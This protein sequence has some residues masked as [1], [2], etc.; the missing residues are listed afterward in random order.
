MRITYGHE[1]TPPELAGGDHLT[2]TVHFT[3]EESTALGA[4]AGML[5]DWY[6]S[7]L[8]ALVELRT[9]EPGQSPYMEPDSWYYLINDMENRL[10]PRLRGIRD[11]LIRAHADDGRSVGDLAVAMDVVKSTAQ[12]RRDA[13]VKRD[14][15]VW[16][17]WARTGGPQGLQSER[18]ALGES[19]AAGVAAVADLPSGMVYAHICPTC[20]TD[21]GATTFSTA[22]V[23]A[24]GHTCPPKTS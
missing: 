11:A 7:A 21:S 23:R 20:G 24:A 2:I 15:S 5:T 16:E 8:L 9:A 12:G 4:E 22:M 19:N 18:P 6:T 13:V 10:A 3:H 14:P 1:P 17:T